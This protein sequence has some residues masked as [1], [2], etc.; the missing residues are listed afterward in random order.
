MRQTKAPRF[1]VWTIEANSATACKKLSNF[2]QIFYLHFFV[3]LW[4][5]QTHLGDKYVKVYINLVVKRAHYVNISET[6]KV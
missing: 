4:F 5:I 3:L 1:V 2:S 6:G